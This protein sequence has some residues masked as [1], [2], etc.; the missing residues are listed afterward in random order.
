[1]LRLSCSND[2]LS[3]FGFGDCRM[4]VLSFLLCLIILSVAP[5]ASAQCMGRGLCDPSV[6]EVRSQISVNVPVATPASTDAALKATEDA[7][8]QLY[9]LAGRECETL[10]QVFGGEC[11]LS[12]VN[13]NSSMQD[14]GMAGPTAFV[15]ISNMYTIRKAA[16]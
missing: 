5:P 14:R 8:K 15:S 4:R 12:S 16:K 3:K 10:H 13:I 9:A 7:R 6:I 2:N 1:M 11:A